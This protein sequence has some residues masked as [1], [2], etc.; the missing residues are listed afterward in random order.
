[1]SYSGIDY[2]EVHAMI[3]VKKSGNH[4][5]SFAGALEI[6]PTTHIAMTVSVP[7][8]N[9]TSNLDNAVHSGTG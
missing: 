7:V 1:M 4:I 6:L 3:R 9:R 2:A 5:I 8:P